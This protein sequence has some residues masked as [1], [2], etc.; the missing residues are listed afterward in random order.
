LDLIDLEPKGGRGNPS[1]L[2]FALSQLPGR[3]WRVLRAQGDP[4][5]IL[6]MQTRHNANWASSHLSRGTETFTIAMMPVRTV[7]GRPSQ[8]CTS[9]A[10]SGDFWAKSA[11]QNAKRSASL[12]KPSL[13]QELTDAGSW[14]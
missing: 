11:K 3:R 12:S 4:L 7:S 14:F 10:K 8:L 1:A 5:V 6:I 13:G 2:S 9:S